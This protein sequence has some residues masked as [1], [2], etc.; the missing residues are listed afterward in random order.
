MFFCLC[1]FVLAFP[2]ALDL[3]IA[4]IKCAEMFDL[5]YFEL[6]LIHYQRA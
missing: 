1:L 6:E 4:D 2:V 5:E 3:V